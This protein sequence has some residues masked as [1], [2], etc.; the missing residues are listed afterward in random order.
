[1]RL[2]RLPPGA[3]VQGS[4]S[5]GHSGEEP[6]S[7]QNHANRGKPFEQDL[8]TSC[9]TYRNRGEA[10]I[11]K[12]P[13]PKKTAGGFHEDRPDGTRRWVMGPAI[14]DATAD[15]SVDFVGLARGRGYA[16][17]AKENHDPASFSLNNIK[18]EQM[19]FL[20][21]W[22]AQGGVSCF[23]MRQ[24]P[25]PKGPTVHIVP[26]GVVAFYWREAGRDHPFGRRPSPGARQSVPVEEVRRWPEVLSGRGVPYDF[27][28][29]LDVASAQFQQDKAAGKW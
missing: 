19:D 23:C 12:V 8:I 3:R 4:T 2:D 28:P 24:V 29:L 22:E 16:F 25:G 17:D 11:I 26:Y 6:D 27:L 13:D 18:P 20:R 1:M 9:R 5:A 21:D 14:P 15:K 10:M 7:K